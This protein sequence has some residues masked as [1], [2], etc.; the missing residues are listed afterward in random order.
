[1]SRR[2]LDVLFG[3]YLA[4]CALCVVWPG[5]AWYGARVEPLVLGLPFCLAWMVGWILATF[6]VLVLY[7]A[8]RERGRS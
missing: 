8:M 4:I 1:M 5:M 3:T 2:T 7:D 6:L